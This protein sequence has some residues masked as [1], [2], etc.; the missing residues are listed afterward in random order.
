MTNKVRIQDDLYHYVNGEWLETA[1]IPDDRPT[2]GG[3][4]ELN[5]GVEQLL[6]K[7]FKEFAANEK[8]VPFGEL[9]EAVKLY[10]QVL[11]EEKRNAEGVKPA[12]PYL[13]EIL[14]I[15]D[16]D[17][18]SAKAKEL[19][20]SGI[21]LPFNFGVDPDMKN[22][23]NNAFIILGPSIILP[24][25]TYYVEGNE[26][27]AA[28]IGVYSNMAKT[29]LDKTPLSEEDKVHFLA[30]ALA[31]DE[32]VAKQV[33]SQLEWADYVANYNP[34]TVEEAAECLKP[35][36]F[37]GLLASL[38][39]DKVP[40]KVI[41][42]D[43]KAIKNFKE[44]FNEG[45]F[46]KYKHWAY[47]TFLV[48]AAKHLSV[49][50]HDVATTFQRTLFGIAK[51][52]VLEKQ[53]YQLAGSFFSE[54]VGMYYGREYFGE[55]AKKDVVNLVKRIIEAYK[56]RMAKNNFLA[57]ET[58]EKAILKLNTIA[59]KMGYPDKIDEFYSE[60][61]VDEN[62]VLF[63]SL[64]KLGAKRIL[65]SLEKLNKPVDRME[66][67][68]PGHMVNACYNP[69]ANDI[70]FPAAILQKPFYGLDQSESEN[71]GG[72]GAVIGHEI[73]HAFDNNGASF[74][75]KG[76]L[77]NWW[78]EEDYAAFKS[79]TKNMID[80]FDGIDF[81]GGK[82]SG[83]LIVS[84]NIADNGGMGVTLGIMH[85]TEGV[86]FQEYFKNWARVWC[87]KAKPQYIQYL[88]VNDVHAPAELRANIQPRNFDEWYEAFDVTEKDGMYI[89]PEKRVRIW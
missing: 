82:V 56:G 45:T 8:Q 53:A 60:L 67:A 54:P 87:L 63:A 48:S 42:Y 61:K 19:T 3:F 15:K 85:E 30:D 28:L 36:D 83:E 32:L 22:A 2:A 80:E 12:L 73:S 81:Y 58:K 35:F 55:E 25:T 50:M 47:V 38:Y 77:N 33:K 68:M 89:A 6:R 84:E 27:G 51:D 17:D 64:K 79:L 26:T 76:N 37:K 70:T 52:P 4:S 14:N 57:P 10:K 86:S 9:G 75:E 13:E 71:L 29:L 20:L 31:F 65:H 40:T 69:F 62:D 18:L 88:L 41:A 43:P 24:D 16:I 1:V 23:E 34:M 46:E 78:K 44:Y 74:D 49:E 72:I 39:G 7:D 5:E 59:I 66:W 21:D 11:D